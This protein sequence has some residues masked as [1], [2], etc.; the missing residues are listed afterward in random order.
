MRYETSAFDKYPNER[1]MLRNAMADLRFAAWN[2]LKSLGIYVDKDK[3]LEFISESKRDN[4]TPIIFDL[5]ISQENTLKECFIQ[6]AKEAFYKS[7]HTIQKVHEY[8]RN[9]QKAAG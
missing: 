8:T 4:S 9:I 7:W 1:A 2:C 3:A 6:D 5:I